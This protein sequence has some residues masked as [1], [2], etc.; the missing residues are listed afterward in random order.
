MFWWQIYLC[1]ALVTA[2]G[3]S[4]GA[5]LFSERDVPVV[6]R[7]GA[8]LLAGVFWPVVL[9]GMVQLICIAGLAKAMRTAGP[10]Q[11]DASGQTLTVR[12]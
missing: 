2:A 4:V 11:R 3:A 12:S 8:I 6:V 10:G 9:V 7:T 1:G 5:D